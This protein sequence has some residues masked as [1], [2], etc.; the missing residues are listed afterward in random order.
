MAA[1]AIREDPVAG[2][3]DLDQEGPRLGPEDLRVDRA[4]EQ[5]RRREAV[6][7]QGGDEGHRVHRLKG[8]R[9]SPLPARDLPAPLRD[10]PRTHA[11]EDPTSRAWP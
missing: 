11:H 2:V 1:E 7:A 8:A 10:I 6:M 5:A 4:V 3:E 9:L